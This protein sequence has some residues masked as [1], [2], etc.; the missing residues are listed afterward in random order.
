MVKDRL[1]NDPKWALKALVRIYREGQTEEEKSSNVTIE[2]NG[3][4]FSG[5]DA[6]ILS[7]IAVQYLRHR[8]LSAKQIDLVMNKIK[9]YSRQVYNFNTKSEW[10]KYFFGNI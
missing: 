9:K 8:M 3:I 7:S 5:C 10:E 6:E 1:S 2:L 4:G